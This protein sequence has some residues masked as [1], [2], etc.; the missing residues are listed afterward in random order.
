MSLPVHSIAA[1]NIVINKHI[2]FFIEAKEDMGM[3]ILFYQL[4]EKI[5][6]IETDQIKFLC[7]YGSLLAGGY[8]EDIDFEK[9]INCK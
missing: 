5:E 3:D 7:S 9:K 4:S 1:S 8:L 6:N 2:D